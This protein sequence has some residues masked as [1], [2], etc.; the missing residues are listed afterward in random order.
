MSLTYSQIKAFSEPAAMAAFLEAEVIGPALPGARL[1][2]LRIAPGRRFEAPRILWNVYQAELELPGGEQ[3]RPLLWTKAFFDDAECQEYAIRIRPLLADRGRGPLDPDGWARLDPERNLFLFFYPADPV[4][5]ALPAVSDPDRVRAVIEPLVEPARP[6]AALRTLSAT[7]IKYLP[8]ISC[9]LRY[10][11]D[12]GQPPPLSFY[13]KVQHSRRG[14]LTFEVM[15]A[16]WE[17]PARA[18]GDLVLAQPL[19][20]HPE[21]ELL[22]QSALPGVEVAGDRHSEVFMRQCEAA[23]RA[24]GHIH[25]SGLTQGPS[26]TLA[27]EV[28]RL[29]HRLEEFKMS[30]PAVYFDLRD[31]LLQVEASARRRTPAEAQ[32]PSHGDFKYNQ[33]LF[34]GERFGLIDVEYFVQA[35][36]SFDLGKYCAH[37]WPSAPQHWSDTAQAALARRTFLSAY[38]SLRPDYRGSRLPLYE[39]VSLATRAL[40]VTWAQ[41]RNW[42]YTAQTL[43]ALAYE[44]LKSRWDE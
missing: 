3:V 20:Y 2:R 38:R 31:L 26:H 42:D 23:G 29:R 18:A 27:L 25:S 39:S 10:D 43:I 11:L 30:S 5:P 19:A 24:I 17:L 15:K 6:N 16:L 44:R 34:D 7:R 28:E 40:V 4:F 1:H 21:L 14:R 13:G 8:E 9:I 36:P 33:F 35:E 32:V 37:L 12:L 22:L 41:S